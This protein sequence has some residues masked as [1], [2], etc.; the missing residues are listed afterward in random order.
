MVAGTI[1]AKKKPTSAQPADSHPVPVESQPKAER[2]DFVRFR[3]S[4]KYK[5]WMGRFATSERS[6]MSDLF[7]DAMAAYAKDR[8]FEPP[9][10]R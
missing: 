10:M 7:D 4:S 1:L 8:G 5:D 6:D 9:P 2:S 3:V